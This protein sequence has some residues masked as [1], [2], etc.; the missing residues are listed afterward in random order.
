MSDTSCSRLARSGVLAAALLLSCLAAAPAVAAA[1]PPAPEAAAVPQEAP[2]PAGGEANLVLP[3]LGLVEFQG[4]NGR[5]LLMGGL[6]VCVL[7]LVFGLVIYM[8]LKNLPVHRSMLEISELIY[9]TC[10]TYLITQGK[11]ILILELF[12]GVDHGLLL[13]RAA[14]LRADQGRDHPAVQP[15]RHRRAATASPGSASA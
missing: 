10:K 7:G 14:A 4:I 3:D 8:Q 9:E 1:Q 2:R 13:R 6:V 12:I 15:G 5:T 11:F